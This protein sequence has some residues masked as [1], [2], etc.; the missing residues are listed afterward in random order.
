MSVDIESIKE[1]REKTGVSVAQ[2]KKALEEAGGDMIRAEELL[3]A[4]GASVA[5]KKSDRGLGS[6]VMG[7][8][9]HGDGSFASLVELA[10]ETDFVAKNEE[11][12]AL[13]NDLAMQVAAFTPGDQATLLEMPFIKDQSM[14]VDGVIKSKVQKFG[15]RIELIRFVRLAVGAN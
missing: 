5:A 15:E 11:F 2:C 4:Q 12:V 1:L 9:V 6:G 10:C 14:T 3:R 13:A 7:A 8:Y